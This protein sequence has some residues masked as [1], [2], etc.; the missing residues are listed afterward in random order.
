MLQHVMTAPGVIEFS[1]VPIPN[2]VIIKIMK[3]GI[4]AQNMHVYH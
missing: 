1:E 2:D 4:C 3:I